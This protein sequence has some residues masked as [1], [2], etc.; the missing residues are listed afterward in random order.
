MITIIIHRKRFVDLKRTYYY[1]LNHINDLIVLPD[2]KNMKIAVGG[3]TLID[4]WCGTDVSIMKHLTPNIYST[5]CEEVSKIFDR[6]YI[7]E[8]NDI[9]DLVRE[10]RKI[11]E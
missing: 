2:P 11:N 10:I 5:D 4:F 3:S 9:K 7:I 6:K 8:I 1:I